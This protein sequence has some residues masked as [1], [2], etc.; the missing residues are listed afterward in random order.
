VQPEIT[1]PG[2]VAIPAAISESSWEKLDRLASYAFAAAI[3]GGGM[4]APLGLAVYSLF[5]WE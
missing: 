4:F 1:H 3:L 5:F 2:I